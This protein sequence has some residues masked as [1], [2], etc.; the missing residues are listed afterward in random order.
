MSEGLPRAAFPGSSGASASATVPT[1]HLASSV[2]PRAGRAICRLPL[3]SEL[4]HGATAA[5]RLHRHDHQAP[6]RR[7]PR[8]S[9]TAG[10]RRSRDQRR[11]PHRR[12][13]HL[14]HP[15]GLL[16]RRD[17]RNPPRKGHSP[18]PTRRSWRWPPL[19]AARR[20]SRRWGAAAQV[21]TPGCCGAEQGPGGEQLR[22]E[23][24]K[25]RDFFNGETRWPSSSPPRPLSSLA[26]RSPSSSSL[27]A[28]IWMQGTSSA[29]SPGGRRAHRGGDD[30]LRRTP[31]ALSLLA[32]GNCPANALRVA[33]YCWKL[34]IFARG[35]Y[36]LSCCISVGYADAD[37]VSAGDG[38]KPLVD[39]SRTTQ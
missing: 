33:R 35:I 9:S 19:L 23:D 16:L 8:R 2:R 11:E 7:R 3:A 25:P 13:L 28:S 12:R 30:E 21:R 39:S 38:L 6:H 20:T 29:A 34:L 5:A 1:V 10:A 14:L 27:L 24:L 22:A 4:A 26:P 32:G 36:P 37:R 18:D 15:P 17:R 31:A